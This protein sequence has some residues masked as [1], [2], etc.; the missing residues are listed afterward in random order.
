MLEDALTYVEG[1]RLAPGVRARSER[2][3][4]SI[5]SGSYLNEMPSRMR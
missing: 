5:Y 1:E 2:D 4:A 3:D